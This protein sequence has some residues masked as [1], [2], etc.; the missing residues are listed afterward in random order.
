MI[1]I[2]S[3]LLFYLYSSIRLQNRLRYCIDCFPDILNRFSDRS[4]KKNSNGDSLFKVLL[5]QI[6][7]IVLLNYSLT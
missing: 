4:F 2:L 7:A 6:E 3:S 5:A 1:S